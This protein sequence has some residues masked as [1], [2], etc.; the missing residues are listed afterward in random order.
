MQG[1][2]PEKW[3]LE[4][5]GDMKVGEFIAKHTY[6]VDCC[7]YFRKDYDK[8]IRIFVEEQKIFDSKSI[9][10]QLFSGMDDPEIIGIITDR[11]EI[12]HEEISIVTK[13]NGESRSWLEIGTLKEKQNQFD[14]TKV[15]WTK[16][17]ARYPH[18]DGRLK[19]KRSFIDDPFSAF[20][21][22]IRWDIKV[23]LDYPFEIRVIS[24]GSILQNQYINTTE[25]TIW[26]PKRGGN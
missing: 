25:R 24:R 16:A 7:L 13:P 6:S 23:P 21:N 12:G 3:F 18:Y 15:T 10:I 17:Q 19:I 22:F 1:Y 20:E 11:E 14:Q 26:E 5:F 4:T 2:F 9:K 8:T